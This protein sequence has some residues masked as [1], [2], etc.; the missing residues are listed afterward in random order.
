M[1]KSTLALVL[2]AAA[3]GA[4]IYFFE[5]KRRPPAEPAEEGKPAFSFQPEDISRIAVIRSGETVAAAKRN[6]EWDITQPVET[7]GDQENWDTIA[8]NAATARISRTLTAAPDRLAAYGLDK[9]AVTLELRL[10]SG[11]EHRLRLGSK[12]FSGLSVYALV[13]NGSGVALLPDLVLTSAA[14][15]LDELRD[16]SVLSFSTWDV[17]GF[18]LK[19]HSGE[20]R[21]SKQGTDWKLEK[22]REAAGD[23]SEVSALLGQVSSA[24]MAGIVSETAENPSKYGLAKPSISFEVRLQKGE[25]RSLVIGGKSGDQYFARDLSRPM[26]FRIEGPLAQKLNDTFFDLRDK[27]VVH[28]ESANLSRVVIRNHYQ[29]LVAERDAEGKWTVEEPAEKKGKTVTASRFLDALENAHA[30]EIFDSP[31]AVLS[32]K[33]SKPAIEVELTDKSGHTT[34]INVS[35]ASGEDVYI[36]TSAS[37][38]V[39]RIGKAI[40]DTLNFKLSDLVF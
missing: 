27:A 6:G 4:F 11:Q 15:P 10:K 31:S 9:P 26:I 7:R 32:A 40:L 22:P 35:A 39:A 33:L 37:P 12:D 19:N 13:D 29:R 30:K 36:R 34:K 17:E 14:K 38:A 20:I 5:F 24:R 23:L 8:R 1:K 18:D 28:F 16:R 2:V 25:T 3:F 21:A